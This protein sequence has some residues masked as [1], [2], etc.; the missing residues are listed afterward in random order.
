MKNLVKIL[1]IIAV[2]FAIGCEDVFE[3]DISESEFFLLAPADN[4]STFNTNITYWWEYVEGARDY[5]LQVVKGSF[6]AI[7]SLELDTVI[8]ENKYIYDMPSGVYQWQVIALNN[9]SCTYSNIHNLTVADTTGNDILPITLIEPSLEYYNT[10][11]LLFS[12]SY[13][14]SSPSYRFEIRKGDWEDN[15]IV[16]SKIISVD[17]YTATLYEGTYNWGVKIENAEGNFIT[18]EI[19][20]DTTAPSAPELTEPLDTEIITEN[21]ISFSW[22]RE[23][24][25]GAPIEFDSLFISDENTFSAAN[26]TGYKVEGST[27]DITINDNDTYYWKVV[28]FD[29]AGNK[30][31]FSEI[32]EFTLE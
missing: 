2:I 4:L 11:E 9:S 6:D 3:D 25:N 31:E 14:G 16:L 20:I 8:S 26:T 19:S 10:T 28:S 30:G 21:T 27:T 18:D 17:S 1:Y 23:T 13:E 5:N 32:N 12:W 24:L 15:D 7:E 22:E 29:Q